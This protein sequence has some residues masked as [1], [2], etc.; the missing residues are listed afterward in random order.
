MKIPLNPRRHEQVQ[1]AIGDMTEYIAFALWPLAA[2]ITNH[3]LGI[4]IHIA[5]GKTD[6]VQVTGF[7]GGDDLEVLANIPQ[8]PALTLRFGQHRIYNHA[9]FKGPLNYLLEAL[10]IVFGL[11]SLR[12]QQG[13]KGIVPRQWRS[14]TALTGD[15]PI[16][17]APHHLVGAERAGQISLQRAQ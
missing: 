12:L 6:I 17:A 1:I 2:D 16:V 7:A 4:G 3:P 11:G 10:T 8:G 9:V 14:M 13:I 5:D 15:I